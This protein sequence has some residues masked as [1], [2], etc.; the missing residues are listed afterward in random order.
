MIVCNLLLFSFSFITTTLFSMEHQIEE[1]VIRI[2]HVTGSVTQATVSTCQT[3]PSGQLALQRTFDIPYQQKHN[4]IPITITTSYLAIVIPEMVPHTLVIP[5]NSSIFPND[6]ICIS[7]D[8]R[9]KLKNN[10]TRKID[11]GYI[12]NGVIYPLVALPKVGTYQKLGSKKDIDCCFDR[13]LTI[14]NANIPN[15]CCQSIICPKSLIPEQKKLKCPLESVIIPTNSHISL[16][17]PGQLTNSQ[18]IDRFLIIKA[19]GALRPLKLRF[20]F[21]LISLTDILTIQ[22]PDGSDNIIVTNNEN[23]WVASLSTKNSSLLLK[24]DV[25]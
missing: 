18:I 25:K 12:I 8:H 23:V 17:I 4:P 22:K 19:T 20:P 7:A 9:D 15:I 5:L 21:P 2:V 14:Y 11:L 16:C 1:Q 10:I 3:T 24:P 6:G 13:L